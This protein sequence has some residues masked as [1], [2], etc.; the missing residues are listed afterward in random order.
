[1]FSPAWKMLNVATSQHCFHK[2]GTVPPD[3]HEIGNDSDINVV[4][5]CQRLCQRLDAEVEMEGFIR[6]DNDIITAAEVTGDL[7]IN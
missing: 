3:E 1:M 5:N 2:V 7:L 4:K 6:V